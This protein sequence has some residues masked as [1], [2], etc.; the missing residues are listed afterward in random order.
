MTTDALS[1]PAAAAG[2]ATRLLRL[3]GDRADV[4]AQLRATLD[5][6]RRRWSAEDVDDWA[7]GALALVHANA[8]GRCLALFCRLTDMSRGAGAAG[9]AA[10][11]C[12][13]AELAR[14][15][16]SK[17]A[18]AALEAA[19]AVAARLAPPDRARWWAALS[20]LA[21]A[22]PDCAEPLVERSAMVLAAGGAHGFEDFVAAG[23]KA[24]GGDRGRLKAFFT[25]ADP[26]AR[27]LLERG[28][29]QA[30]F[31]EL[32]RGLVLFGAALWGAPPRLAPLEGVGAAPAPQ[33]VSLA[34]DLIRMPH[35]YRGVPA[36]AAPGPYRAALAHA[37]AHRVFGGPRRP[38][39]KLK[40]LQIALVGLIE[41]ARVE[42]LAMRRFPGLR[43]L[44]APWHVARPVAAT[45]AALLMARLARALFD[46]DYQDP[47]GFVAK[48]RRL[49]ADAS[50]RLEDPTLARAIGGLL[51]NDIGQMRLRFDPRGYVVEPLY[52]DDNLGLWDFGDEPDAEAEE[53]EQA[54]DAARPR[55]E[56]GD[57][58]RM[59][60]APP[61][62]EAGRAREIEPDA[63][64]QVVAS[65]P[66]WDRAAGVERAR[67]T[68]VRDA[69]AALGD[70]RALA[71]ALEALPGFRQRI[72]RL[73]RGARVGRAARLKRQPE[74]FDLDL[75]AAVEA[76]IALRVG[77]IPEGRIHRAAG[78]RVRDVATVAL[79]DVSQSTRDR[80]GAA[81]VLEIEKL[82][83]AALG[84]AMDAIGD[85]FAVRAFASCGRDEVRLTRVKEFSGRMD[86]AA[87]ARLAGLSS[88]L[89]TRL[90]AALRHA[91]AELAPLRSHRKLVLALT[92]GEPS[93]I[94]VAD[95]L[96]LVEDARRAVLGLR[97]TG[98]DVF[99]VT[100][101][102]GCDARIFGRA[103][104]LPVRRIE[105]L[106][107]RLSELYFRLA[108][109]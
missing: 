71:A 99:G 105:E 20:R 104:T 81:T 17:A 30:G 45:N 107:A 77:E 46:P 19:P 9:L 90:G 96:D 31:H 11:A 91:G 55:P 10:D 79:V 37:M 62:E 66:E 92:D 87:M 4:G 1:R 76:G 21:C 85:R 95:P 82:A 86:A 39:G 12:A 18:A 74:G 43:A 22:A 80:V 51:G 106:P 44:W 61:R 108:R 97:R 68:T 59:A 88:G 13:A 33:R 47:D 5:R 73:V 35:V 28:A 29:G 78:R 15:A 23:L 32:E 50:G 101:G 42:A 58:G 57:D 14:G 38:A 63:A 75:D 72:A 52:R 65:Y 34:G 67:W 64:G 24:G 100:L 40:P 53:I 83:V 70:R 2:A 8:G 27:R 49:F 69:P 89:S 7:E 48:G 16:G 94:D 84:A 103:N 102:E 56:E 26:A 93:D 41:D 6:L 36:D 25:L 54:V 3:A 60:D 98:V 109:L